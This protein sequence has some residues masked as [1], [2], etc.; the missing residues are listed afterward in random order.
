M[1]KSYQRED[2]AQERHHRDDALD[3]GERDLPVL[4]PAAGAIDG[5][6]VVQAPGHG[7]HR[8]QERDAEERKAAPDVGHDHRDHRQRGITEPV[9]AAPDHAHVDQRHVDEPAET[10]PSATSR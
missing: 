7:L 2:R 10:D 4:V 3:A 8:R 5:G 9:H 1:L 6:G